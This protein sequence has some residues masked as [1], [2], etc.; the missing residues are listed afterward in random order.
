[1][2]LNCPF[3]LV[4][5]QAAIA[6]HERRHHRRMRSN[7]DILNGCPHIL[8]MLVQAR[9]TQVRGGAGSTS[10][11]AFACALQRTPSTAPWSARL[12][13]RR[14]RAGWSQQSS[15]HTDLP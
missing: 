8:F 10:W 11:R 12:P 2:Q 14:S 7:C 5:M 15:G 1:M 4:G 3:N 13:A 9:P 6:G